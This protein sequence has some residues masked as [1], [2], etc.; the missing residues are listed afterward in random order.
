MWRL[1]MCQESWEGVW[2]R[3][4]LN[5][6]AL[7]LLSEATHEQINDILHETPNR[8]RFGKVATHFCEIYHKILQMCQFLQKK[9]KRP[10][11]N[12]VQQLQ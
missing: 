7:S 10:E 5:L 1:E 6:L 12:I 4:K 9:K 2:T 8:A 3:A 11:Y